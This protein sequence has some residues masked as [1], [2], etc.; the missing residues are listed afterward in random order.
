MGNEIS[1]VGGAAATAVT[2]VAAG[3]TLGQVE[4][5]NNAVV[6]SAKFT[7]SKASQTIVRHAGETVVSGTGL[8]LTSVAAGVTLGQV[9][10]LNEAVVGC[11]EHTVEAG[12]KTC[13]EVATTADD[14]VDN[15]PVVG[16]IKGAIH[17]ACD[18][19]EGGDKAMKSASRTTGVVAGAVVGIPGGPVCMMAGGAAGGAA[20]DGITTGVESAIKG[21]YTPSGQIEAWTRVAQ[22]KNSE[23]RI[24]GIVN[25]VITP[26]FD[27]L[28]GRAAGKTIRGPKTLLKKQP[29]HKYRT[30]G[31]SGSE[32]SRT[33]T[34][35]PASG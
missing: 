33:L 35:Y 25:G 5:L 19:K 21:K 2:A 32:H 1:T 16:H 6:E 23:E 8:V 10:S 27:G 9:D 3:V 11:F 7:G 20:M 29:R 34:S 14:L 28:L 31:G 26:V 18:D 22:A 13:T 4:T 15:V 12:A 30:R 24:G 17:Y